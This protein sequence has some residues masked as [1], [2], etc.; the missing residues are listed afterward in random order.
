M[1]TSIAEFVSAD[2]GFS[3]ISNRKLLALYS[4]MAE[5]RRIAEGSVAISNGRGRRATAGSIL[6][7]EAALVGAAIDLLPSD[8]IIS[9]LRPEAALKAVNPA[10]SFTSGLVRAT[11]AALAGKGDR[12]VSL[13]FLGS[14]RTAQSS[15]IRALTLAVEQN[16]PIL[17]VLLG[18]PGA[19]ATPRTFD[20]IQVKRRGYSLPVIAVDGNDVVAVYR[21]ASESLA[22]ARKG[23]GPTLIDCRLSIPADAIQ[24]MRNDLVD[25]GLDPEELA[26]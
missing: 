15:W 10:P 18:P 22:H 17:F 3:L 5:C 4:A 26:G 14:T 12:S 25:K 20:A 7:H 19:L 11:R 24:N 16:L 2:R 23:H 1:T 9:A 8:T 13:V 21:V 6:G